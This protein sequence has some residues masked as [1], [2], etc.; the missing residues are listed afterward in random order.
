MSFVILD[1]MPAFMNVEDDTTGE[2]GV[3]YPGQSVTPLMGYQLQ[4]SMR[5]LTI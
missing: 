2:E 3:D 1:G 4:N 5:W